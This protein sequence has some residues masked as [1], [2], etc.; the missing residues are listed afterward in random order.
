MEKFRKLKM[1]SGSFNAFY[2]EFIKLVAKLKFTK[3][4]L[5]QEFMHKLFPRM[6]DRRNSGLEYPDNIKDLAARCQ[7]IYDQMMAT[8]R[9]QSNTKQANTKVANIS[10]R[11]IPSNMQIINR[12]IPFSPQ[13]TSSST[14]A[15]CP[16]PGN[17]FSPLTNEK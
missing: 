15:Y 12:S 1:G 14:N 10:T 4:M 16:R 11:F 6:Q 5:L 3:E 13:A 2:L 7:K 8:N 17:S 9:V